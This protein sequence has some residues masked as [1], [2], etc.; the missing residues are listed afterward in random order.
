MVPPMSRTTIGM[1]ITTKPKAFSAMVLSLSLRPA[2]LSFST[3][4]RTKDFTT[5]MAFKSSCTTWFRSSVAPCKEVKN[6]PTFFSTST[7]PSTSRGIT[8][9]NIRLNLVLMMSA[10]T[11]AVTSITGARTSI[12]IPIISVICR[13][14]TSLVSR[15]MRDAVEKCS[16]LAKENF[17]TCRYSAARRFA[18]KPML[19][20]EANMAAPTPNASAAR[21]I[22]AILR[23]A[24]R[25]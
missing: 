9:R 21:A 11:R 8:T 10:M 15:V 16:I 4:S 17:C 6:G 14:L 7:T 18:P 19:A 13:L 23:P 12:R 20:R 2:N 1:N 25:I 22:T 24:M 5:R 3:S